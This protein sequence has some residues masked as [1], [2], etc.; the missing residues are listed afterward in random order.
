MQEQELKI[1]VEIPEWL[2]K[3]M[4]LLKEKEIN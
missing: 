2:V 1:K 3:L 4:E